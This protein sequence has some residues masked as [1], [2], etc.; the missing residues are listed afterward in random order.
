MATK[1]QKKFG[2]NMNYGNIKNE[3]PRG[4]AIEVLRQSH[5]GFRAKNRNLVF[6]SPETPKGSFDLSQGEVNWKPQGKPRGIL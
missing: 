3:L 4:R 5:F 1:E 6:T 2:I